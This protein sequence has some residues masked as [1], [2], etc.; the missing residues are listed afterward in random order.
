MRHFIMCVGV[1]IFF[2][3][4]SLGFSQQQECADPNAEVRFDHPRCVVT[5]KQRNL[6]KNPS[7]CFQPDIG[8]YMVQR[9]FC[10]Q[11]YYLNEA[12]NRCVDAVQC[13]CNATNGEVS[14]YHNECGNN[15]V[16]FHTDC[17]PLL[18]GGCW[19]DNISCRTPQGACVLKEMYYSTV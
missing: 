17:K 11:N 6:L 8:R 3:F 4:I 2:T 12:T 15:C 18:V 9:C 13:P 1:V 14:R 10:K 19:C 16:T 5:C 7:F